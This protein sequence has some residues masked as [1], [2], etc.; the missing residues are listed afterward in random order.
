MSDTDTGS[1][2]SAGKPAKKLL[3]AYAARTNL[4]TQPFW[5]GAEAGVLR[6]PRCNQCERVIWYPR[7]RCDGCGSTDVSW[8]DASGNGSVYSC[9]IT[10]RIPGRWQASAPFVV[11]YVELDEGPRVLTN[12]I[13][14]D[15][16]Q[17]AIGMAVTAAFQPTEEGPPLLRFKPA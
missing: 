4:E 15:P 9:T 3:P 7:Q 5:D 11:A 2:K 1:D 6:L 8:F 16:E 12:V 10:R 17:V 14:C 13:D